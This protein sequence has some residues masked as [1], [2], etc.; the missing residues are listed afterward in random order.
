MIFED[1]HWADPTSR[2]LLDLIVGK[3]Q[4]LPVL[5]I[6]TFRPEFQAPWTGQPH[7]TAVALRRLGREESGALVR[8]L[9][10]GTAALSGAVVD[11]IVD[12]TDGVL[13]FAEELTKAVLETGDDRIAGVLAA[14]GLPDLVIPA[15]LHALA[16]RASRSARANR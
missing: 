2:E 5:L 16:S 8:G 10:G 12:R 6:A 14:R 7:V 11:E 3:I 13:L 15:T 1:L 9:I 4:R